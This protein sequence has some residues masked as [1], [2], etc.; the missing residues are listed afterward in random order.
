M[1]NGLIPIIKIGFGFG[2]SI[3]I[4]FAIKQ[5]LKRRKYKHIPGPN[6]KGLLLILFR[7]VLKNIVN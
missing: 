3:F 7:K 6:T 2:S 4:Y 1:I 5:Y